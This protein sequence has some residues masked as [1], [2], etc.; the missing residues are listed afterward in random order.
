[1]AQSTGYFSI[2]LIKAKTPGD[3]NTQKHI[4]DDESIICRNIDRNSLKEF[5]DACALSKDV[6]FDNAKIMIFPPF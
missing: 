3:S 2:P 4:F 5:Q 6:V 1:M